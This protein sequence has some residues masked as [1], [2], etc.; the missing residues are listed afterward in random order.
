MDKYL[1]YLD[2]ANSNFIY[3]LAIFVIIFIIFQSLI[4]MRKA[5]KQGLKIGMD[6]KILF[7][8]I[9][10][11]MVFSIVPSIPIVIALMAMAPVLG[12][13]FPWIRLSIIGSSVYELLSA[14]I[15]AQ[16]MGISGLGGDGYTAVVFANSLWV[17]SVGI[18]WGLAAS[19]IGLKKYQNRIQK[20]RGKDSKWTEIFVLSLYFGMISVFIG[21]PIVEGGIALYTMIFSAAV[22][23]LI[24]FIINK[25][26]LKRLGDFALS[27]SMVLGM[28]FA[29]IIG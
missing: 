29:A 11:S 25:F 5:Y 1:D 4:F 22:M 16:S 6:K 12:I 10:S 17:M 27:I 15:G 14:N 18:I 19:I 26:K 3:G 23:G 20:S 8:T 24:T 9:K 28:V 21:Q 2:V 7:K 13:P